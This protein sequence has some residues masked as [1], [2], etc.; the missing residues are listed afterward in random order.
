MGISCFWTDTREILTMP[1]ENNLWIR[2]LTYCPG[3]FKRKLKWRS[4]VYCSKDDMNELTLVNECIQMLYSL[5]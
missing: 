5:C 3:S 4:M 1:A 2:N